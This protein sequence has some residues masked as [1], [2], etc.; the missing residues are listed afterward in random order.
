MYFLTNPNLFILNHYPENSENSLLNNPIS[1]NNFGVFPIIKL[2]NYQDVRLISPK[3]G[4]LKRAKKQ[5]FTFRTNTRIR[6]VSY[7]LDGKF[8]QIENHTTNDRNLLKFEIDLNKPKFNNL[9]IFIN[10]R[11]I[12][13]YRIE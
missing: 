7:Y 9:G 8:N 12:C 3:L 4:I 1:K 5:D 10:G 6:T 13:E 2:G 11:E